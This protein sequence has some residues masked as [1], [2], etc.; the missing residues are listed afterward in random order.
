MTF[1]WDSQTFFNDSVTT[2]VD[3]GELEL[4]KT[5]DQS[6][7]NWHLNL[8]FRGYPGMQLPS[9]IWKQSS[10]PFKNIDIFNFNMIKNNLE[11]LVRFALHILS[12]ARC[13]KQSFTVCRLA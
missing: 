4:E 2:N 13:F 1:K 7:Q 6:S 12:R 5:K 3:Y 9:I 10:N 11:G 8:V